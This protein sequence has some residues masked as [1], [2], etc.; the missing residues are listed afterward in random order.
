MDIKNTEEYKT[1]L[2]NGRDVEAI[3][4]EAIKS[5]RYQKYKS[6]ATRLSILKSALCKTASAELDGDPFD[7]VVIVFGGADRWGGNPK[8]PM[9]YLAM[10]KNKEFVRIK[11]WDTGLFSSMPCKARVVGTLTSDPKYGDAVVPVDDGVSAIEAVD[12]ETLQKALM[13][14]A[15]TPQDH[16][17]LEA[18]VQYNV[19]Y[20][21]RGKIQW[22]NPT[23]IWQDGENVGLNDV[24]CN[25]ENTPPKK[26]VTCSISINANDSGV[27]LTLNL[28]RPRINHPIVDIEDFEALAED[29]YTENPGDRKKQGNYLKE[30]LSGRDVIAVGTVSGKKEKN[31]MLYVNVST[32]FLMEV[33]PDIKPANDAPKI[34]EFHKEDGPDV[35]DPV[36]TSLSP[37]QKIVAAIVDF[38]L[39]NNQDPAYIP[40]DK[41]RSIAEIGAEYDD[42]MVH[43]FK[44]A[45]A[46]AWKT[47]KA[48]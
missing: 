41:A 16:G 46:L 5:E 13:K 8:A 4:A 24:F 19:P 7:E 10:K 42:N 18:L 17:K 36:D 12:K 9:H 2:K 37:E 14:V 32:A 33:N 26:C 34:D 31:N 30:V 6:E 20:A 47:K 25:D 15:I 3:I 1:A 21:F 22:I 44:K 40:S 43:E 38:G 39:I 23:S 45:A 29:A 27:G 48:A 28:D 11:T 35:I